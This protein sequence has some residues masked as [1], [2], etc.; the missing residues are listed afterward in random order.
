[1]NQSGVK[2]SGIPLVRLGLVSPLTDEL[3][4]RNINCQGVLS[5]FKLSD[6]E[7]T[8]GDSFVTAPVM[9]ALVERLAEI[10][11]DPH[12]GVR[13]GEKLDPFAW[14]PLVN[15]ADLSATVGEFLLRFLIDAA[16]DAS[17]V[18]YRL[19]TKG[20]RTVF[21]EQ[22]KIDGGI[23]P[24]H[25]DG[26]TIAFL[27]S[28]FSKVLGENWQ[29][30]KVLVRLCDPA[31]L[32]AGYL[33]VHTAITDTFGASIR[34]PSS[35][36][37]FPLTLHKTRRY[38]AMDLKKA[39]IPDQWIEAFRQVLQGHVH[40]FDLT[41]Q[42]IAEICGLSKR[43]LAR[44]LKSHGTCVRQEVVT[45]RRMQAE[46]KLVHGNDKVAEIAM[47]LGYANATVFS[48][49]FKRWTGLSPV[50]YRQFNMTE[51]GTGL[52]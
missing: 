24:R 36:L 28:I 46:H 7:I 14:S 29:G 4:R 3:K 10:S 18:S 47:M 22:R 1:M 50:R 2:K 21:H 33:G 39:P 8:D 6:S 37:L 9:Y 41:T 15:S 51:T 42:R 5:E 38:K 43:T 49:A 32:P 20:S 23:T 25:N 48:R 13:V 52:N 30:E 27:L 31:V 35:W 40:E 26:F 17:S 11:G 34:F 44:R 12:F 45:I 19:E 16:D